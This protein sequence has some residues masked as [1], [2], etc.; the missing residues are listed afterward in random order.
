[1]QCCPS[2]VLPTTASQPFSG[3][4]LSSFQASAISHLRFAPVWPNRWKQ[5]SYCSFTMDLISNSQLRLLCLS[6]MQPGA[7]VLLTSASAHMP[8]RQAVIWVCLP[9]RYSPELFPPG[10]HLYLQGVSSESYL[11]LIGS[12]YSSLWFCRICLSMLERWGDWN[13]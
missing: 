7:H 6:K 2:S 12:L 3:S 9:D 4:P 1:M 5:C 8:P 11:C 10:T 13:E